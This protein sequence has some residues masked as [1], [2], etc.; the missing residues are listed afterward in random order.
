MAEL[1]MSNSDNITFVE[2]ST[3]DFVLTD[4]PFNISKK[5]NF[6]TY[7]K[8]SIHSY[9]FD[10]NSEETW[11][12]YTHEDFLTKLDEWSREW[13]R[14]L[15]RGGNFAIFCADAY[16]SHLIEALKANSLHPRRVVTWRKNNA[17]PINRAYMPMSATEYVIVGVKK[18]KNTV[19]NAD[20]SLTEQTLDSR[21]VEANIVADKISTIVFAKVK[22]KI[23][24]QTFPPDF[25]D[26]EHIAAM[27]H[28]IRETLRNSE[29]EILEKVEKMYKVNTKNEKYLQACIPN[30]I[31]SPLKT[32]KRLHPTEKP[33]QLLQHFIALYTKTGDTVLD[34]FGGSGSTGEAA[35]TLNRN[36]IIVERDASFYQSLVD[37]LTPHATVV[38]TNPDTKSLP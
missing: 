5:T 19:F 18:G 28:I 14:V 34:G 38:R 23:F 11:D 37:R 21:I 6:H 8:N 2:D 20:I 29:E 32:G 36:A 7:E 33:V 3:V 4:P 13:A 25:T 30:Y 1:L 22:E 17:V 35:L 10:E 12:T 16:I 24:S 9:Q 15:R 26:Q 31:Q 27:E